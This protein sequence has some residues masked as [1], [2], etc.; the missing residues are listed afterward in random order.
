MTLLIKRHK[1][2]VKDFK[3]VNLSDKHFTKFIL[4]LSKLVDNETLPSEAKDH[5]LLGSWLGYREFH[6]SGDILVIYKIVNRELW[7]IRIGS[8]S[9]LFK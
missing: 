7:L 4:Y 8:H 2:F 6:I 3:R 9:E 5:Q 1:T